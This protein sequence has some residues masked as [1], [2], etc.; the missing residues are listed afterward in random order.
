MRP[1]P[2][3][4][5]S[6]VWYNSDF[7]LANHGKDKALNFM[8]GLCQTEF[9]ASDYLPQGSCKYDFLAKNLRKIYYRAPRVLTKNLFAFIIDNTSD[10]DTEDYKVYFRFDA[11]L[12]SAVVSRG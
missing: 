9:I 11:F 8:P 4:Q 3:Y 12:F 2:A 5:S 6:R 1:R 7:L 10:C